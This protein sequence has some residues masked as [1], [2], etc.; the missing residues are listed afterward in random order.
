V[1]RG[2]VYLPAVLVVL[3]VGSVLVEAETPP[4]AEELFA[5]FHPDTPSNHREPGVVVVQE[6]AEWDK[7]LASLGNPGGKP[8]DF[9]TQAVLVVTGQFLGDFCRNTA[10]KR[11]EEIGGG[12]F[13]VTVEETYPEKC[14]GGAVCRCNRIAGAPPPVGNSVIAL[15]VSKPITGADIETVSLIDKCCPK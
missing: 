13:K 14:S 4:P 10:I 12:R 5:V 3:G 6:S 2:F 8:V 9:S 11:V 1:R 7:V 15:K